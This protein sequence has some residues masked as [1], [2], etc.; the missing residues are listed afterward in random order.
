M[1]DFRRDEP[2]ARLCR[3]PA[4]K[5]VPIL[6][7][8]YNNITILLEKK[9]LCTKHKSFERENGRLT[10]F[11]SLSN[12]EGRILILLAQRISKWPLLIGGSSTCFFVGDTFGKGELVERVGKSP[13]FMDWLSNSISSATT[14]LSSAVDPDNSSREESSSY[15]STER[16]TSSVA[17]FTPSIPDL[18]DLSKMNMFGE[19]DPSSP[20]NGSGGSSAAFPPVA[21]PSAPKDF[22]DGSTLDLDDPEE[23]E[24]K[25]NF[26]SKLLN[27][28]SK[29]NGSYTPG[30][31]L[32][33]LQVEEKSNS[34]E[35]APP[36]RGSSASDII[37]NTVGSVQ[38]LLHQTE[39]SIMAAGASTARRGSTFGESLLRPGGVARQST[40]VDLS[41]GTKMKRKKIQHVNLVPEKLRVSHVQKIC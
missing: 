24:Q 38:N 19:D 17:S 6:W 10:L 39:T 20:T 25:D 7:P 27:G 33:H 11:E 40:M 4:P 41:T 13:Q 37:S 22:D 31:S 21:P 14:V 16:L 15:F 28:H 36:R 9:G 30:T 12:D 8:Y 3:P 35:N 26:D 5:L 23:D 2:R 32:D 18:S 1:L 29:S 34:S